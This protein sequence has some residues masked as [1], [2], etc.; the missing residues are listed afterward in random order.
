MASQEVPDTT[1]VTLVGQVVDAATRQPIANVALRF[2]S[3]GIVRI[4]DINGDF[5]PI[6]IRPGDYS[7]SL[8]RLGYQV[9][10]GNFTVSRAGSF[11]FELN[12]LTVPSTGEPSEIIGQVTDRESGEP[13]VAATVSFPGTDLVRLTDAE[14]RFNF[15]RV[16]PGIRTLRVEQLGYGTREDSLFIPAGETVDLR[17]RLGVQPIELEGITVMAEAR[18]RFLEIGGFY[19]RRDWGLGNQ[20]TQEQME[21]RNTLFLSDLVRTIPGLQLEPQPFGWKIFSRRRVGLPRDPSANM[22]ARCE[23]AIYVDGMRMQDFDLDSLDPMNVQAFEVYH[24]ISETPIEYSHHC[25]VILV[26]LRN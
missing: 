14:G 7:L 3:L 5:G 13:L 19:K 16:P 18:D 22:P 2:P 10:E 20:W 26:W 12:P 11:V 6:R 8:F 15:E 25:G 17:V 23:L 21:E 4:S 1:Q 24:G 9:A